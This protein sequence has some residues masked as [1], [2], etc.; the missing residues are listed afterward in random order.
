MLY[1]FRRCTEN[2]K[3]IEA[4]QELSIVDSERNTKV[5]PSLYMFNRAFPVMLLGTHNC[6]RPKGVK[7][8][9]PSLYVQL[10][11]N[12]RGPE[13]VNPVLLAR[14]CSFVANA[15]G[16]DPAVGYLEPCR[17]RRKTWF[18]PHPSGTKG[19]AC[20]SPKSLDGTEN[21]GARFPQLWKTL[22]WLLL[23]SEVSGWTRG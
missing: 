1:T 7:I 13:A 15:D 8:S 14:P 9:A 4:L 22:N 5:I 11:R 16:D 23:W 17:W 18:I 20:G 21:Q 3:V 10:L 6:S 12:S 2:G 19:D